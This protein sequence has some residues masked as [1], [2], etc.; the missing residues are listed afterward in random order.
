MGNEYEFSDWKKFFAVVGV[1]VV[2]SLL[3]GLYTPSDEQNNSPSTTLENQGNAQD[4]IKQSIVYVRYEFT[5]KNEDGKYFEGEIT[6]SGVILSVNNSKMNIYT[7]R[8]VIDCGY[9]EDCYQ[10]LSERIT[11]RTQ[12]GKT[13]NVQEALI[14]PHNLDLSVLTIETSEDYKTSLVRFDNPTLGEEVTA[15]GYPGLQ[16]INNVLEFSVSKG[17]ITNIRDLLTRDGFSFQ[18]IDSDAYANFGS[19]GGGIFDSYGNLVGIT[20]WKTGT[21]ENIAIT[22]K[23]INQNN[24]KENFTLCEHGSYVITYKDENLCQPYCNRD[25]VLGQDFKCY[26]VCKNFYCKSDKINGEDSRCDDGYILG[27]DNYCHPPCGSKI[28]YCPNF[29]SICYK[30][31]CINNCKADGKELFDIL[32]D[33]DISLS[34][35]FSFLWITTRSFVFTFGSFSCLYICSSCFREVDFK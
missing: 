12:D 11:I 29:N 23:S 24:Q 22:S 27:N 2:I 17:K 26:G 8:H 7:N 6:G 32:K 14:A 4:L 5:S 9:T 1:I 31:S 3:W 33:L 34:S 19:S 28:I 21:Q 30:G 20:T 18:A 16:G 15:V 10:R 35:F 13:H 25:E